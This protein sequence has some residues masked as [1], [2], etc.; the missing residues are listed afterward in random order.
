M[1]ASIFTLLLIALAI[2]CSA[3]NGLC[4]LNSSPPQLREVFVFSDHRDHTIMELF[5][6]QVPL[7]LLNVI[8]IPN[9]ERKK[10]IDDWVLSGQLHGCIFI[11]PETTGV[12]RYCSPQEYAAFLKAEQSRK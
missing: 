11:F 4:N 5:G 1:K 2:R 7:Q 6:E 9:A 12:R 3:Q 8:Y 10:E